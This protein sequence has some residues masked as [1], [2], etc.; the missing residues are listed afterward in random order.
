MK[1]NNLR[2]KFLAGFMPMFVGSF[3]VFFAI[4]YYMSSQALFR[5]ANT[6]SQEVG[7]STAMEIEKTF[8]QKELVVEG[9]AHNHGIIYGDRERRTKILA[10]MM[11]KYSG[12]AMLAY[13]D[14]NGQ[15]FS[16]KGKD[17]DRSTRDYIKAVRE[18]KKPFMTGPSVSGTSGKLITIIAYPVLDNG[19]LTGIIYGT[20]ELD[21]ISDVVGDIKYMDSGYVYIADQDGLV[22]AYAQKPDDVGQLD[23]SKETSSKTIDKALVEGYKQAMQEDRQIYTEYTTSSGVPSLAVMTPIHLANRNW[24]AVSAAPLA[25][26]RAAAD[27]LVAVMGLVGLA[28]IIVISCIIWVVS[29]KMAAPVIALRDRKSVV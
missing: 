18:T 28:M 3:I 8:Q 15:A 1:L 6:I 9:I 2:V 10:D 13:S 14:V 22:I 20:I 21:N 17:M 19:E 29:G 24:L 12:F 7:K 26:I 23:I 27:D 16:D 5:D 25:E 4:S 11:K